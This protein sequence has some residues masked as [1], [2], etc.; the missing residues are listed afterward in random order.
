M[1]PEMLARLEQLHATTVAECEK[2]KP[3]TVICWLGDNQCMRRFRYPTFQITV[4]ALG[5]FLR[6]ARERDE[7]VRLAKQLV[8]TLDCEETGLWKTVDM[9]DEYGCTNL[10]GTSFEEHPDVEGATEQLAAFLTRVSR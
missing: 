1:S 6:A 4:E 3:C 7:A 8:D 10:G 5:F 9:A 2:S